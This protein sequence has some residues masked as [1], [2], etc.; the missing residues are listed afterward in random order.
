MSWATPC[1]SPDAKRRPAIRFFERFAGSKYSLLWSDGS[2]SLVEA[3][4]IPEFDELG[5]RSV[6]HYMTWTS[7]A[8][9]AR[10]LPLQALLRSSEGAV[11]CVKLLPDNRLSVTRQ[12]TTENLLGE[13]ETTTTS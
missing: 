1:R 4:L 8:A 3:Q 7:V 9:R 11:T 5:Q 13:A 12:M 10:P 2:V 6:K